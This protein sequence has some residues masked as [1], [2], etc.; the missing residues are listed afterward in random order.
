VADSAVA[1]RS[2]GREPYVPLGDAQRAPTWVADNGMIM[3]AGTAVS[4]APRSEYVSEVQR[5]AVSLS[6]GNAGSGTVQVPG[7]E[8]AQ[9]RYSGG[10]AVP[11]NT[12]TRREI[13]ELGERSVGPAAHATEMSTMVSG[14]GAL[15]PQHGRHSDSS[16]SVS[17]VHEFVYETDA[18]A[19]SELL[20]PGQRSPPTYSQHGPQPPSQRR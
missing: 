15:Q 4:V 8:A 14:V 18:T 1:A 16:S 20:Q 12:H 7:Y 10:P 6:V 19:G 13:P 9:T 3:S 2:S 17:T 5:P 11:S